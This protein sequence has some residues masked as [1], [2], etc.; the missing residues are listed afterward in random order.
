MANISRNFIAGKMNKVVDERL[1]PN[2]EYIDALN[3]RMGSTENSEMG[4]I[5]NAKGNLPLTSLAYPIDGTPLSDQATTIGAF[6]DG[7]NE[8]LYWFVH[9]PAFTVGATG[10]LDLIV[11]FNTLTNILTYH[12]TSVDDGD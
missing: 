10:K 11:S 3:I 6:E 8:T 2:G 9:D 5:E 4:T 12:V 1:V 7:A